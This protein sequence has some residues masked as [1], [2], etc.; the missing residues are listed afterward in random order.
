LQNNFGIG[1]QNSYPLVLLTNDT[2]RMRITSA[3]NVLMGTTINN[4]YR[5][6]VESAT[7]GALVWYSRG[8]ANAQTFLAGST[9]ST[10][11]F[12][13][14]VGNSQGVHLAYGTTSWAAYSDER[15][16]NINNNIDNAVNDLMTLKA[17]NFSWKSDS[18]NKEN[19][20]LIAQDVEKVFPQIVDKSKKPNSE[21][22]TEYLS[23][24][25]TELVPVLVKAIQELKQELEILKNK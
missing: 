8:D 10:S 4:N 7:G 22:K 15:L 13:I 11:D 1:T 25:Y 6:G 16:K 19:L 23:V 17:V 18:T 9:A 21:D 3:G 14:T 20:G 12:Y 2:E 5:L 24:R